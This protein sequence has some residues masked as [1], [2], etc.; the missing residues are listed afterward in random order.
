[1]T[2]IIDVSSTCGNRA[3]ALAA[4]GVKTIIR[5]YSRDTTRP[6]KRVTRVE[7]NQF[8]ASGLRL[9]I[10][11][12]GRR[13]NQATNFD[14]SCGV[15]DALYSRQYGANEIG[16]P[17]G[18][19][20]YFGIDF[21][22]SL[23]EIRTRIIP[24]FQGIAD[25]FASQSDLPHYLVGVYGSGRTC[26]A[27][28]NAGLASFAWLA[29]STGWAG[30][31]SF[32]DSRRWALN[33]GMPVKDGIAGVACDPNTAS[34]DGGIGEFVL[35]SEQPAPKPI[36][37]PVAPSAAPMQMFVNARGGLHLRTGPGVEFNVSRLLAFGTPVHPLKSVGS[38]TS[39]DLQGDGAADG[40]VSNAYLT[41]KAPNPPSVSAAAPLTTASPAHP[42]ADAMHVPELI[43]QG[44][45]ADGLKEARE[46]AA[47]SLPGYPTNGCA[48][49]LSA[50]LQQS[51]ID[52]PMTWGAGKLAHILSDR[53]WSKIAVGDQIP[54]DVG[55][56]FDNTSPP[57]SDHVY[58]VISTSGP[59]KMTIAD[60]QR[61]V[62][63]PHER[64]ASGQGKTPTEYFLR[65]R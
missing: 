25:A 49:H 65:A 41:D 26:D 17:G 43:R 48:A 20:I 37:A 27:I 24:Y 33:Q 40:F 35:P 12:E 59:D 15:A 5:Y 52:V 47:A 3:S 36:S 9:G 22:A 62:D 31:Q 50:L 45:S 64:F 42:I 44:S 56:C 10:V 30:H 39:I 14:R 29:Q 46:T 8:C 18:T 23:D 53:G 51:G 21:D 38:W 55:V 32:L 60:N 19:A 61:D 6:S 28:L 4:A 54:G 16:Q 34:N 11:H 13:G 58:L 2:S 1:M 57:G 63:A 7:A